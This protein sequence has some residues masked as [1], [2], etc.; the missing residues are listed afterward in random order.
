MEFGLQMMNHEPAR[1]RDIAQV[2]EGLGFAFLCVPDHFLYEG[3]EHQ[4][5]PRHPGF[6]PMLAAAVLAGATTRARIGHLVLCNLFRHPMLTARSLTGLDHLSGGR[7]VA[8]LG[9][10]WTEREFTMTG[11]PFPDVTTRLR[12]LDEALRCIRGLWTEEQTTF[13]GEF[14]RLDGAVH[15][16]KPV[17][18]PHPPILIG[19]G[20]KGLLR[21]AARHADIVNVIVET[22]RTGYIALGEVAKLTDERF[23]SRVKFLRDCAR[24]EG[25]DPGKIQISNVAFTTMLTK[26]PEETQEKAGMFAPMF[27]SVEGAL[28]SPNFLIGTPDEMITEIRRRK[29][30]WDIDQ[31][32]IS[33]VNEKALRAFGEQVM[34]HVK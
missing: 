17:Q 5:D 34:P 18:T 13:Q 25:R 8:G 32:I 30:T 33:F 24:E 23:Q 22:G 9:G 12:M 27:G 28:R 20:G 11:I 7:L 4:S 21:V 26:S 14:Y 16:P 3:P 19:G 1:L 6:D 29:Q 15:W 10:G 31:T 2:A